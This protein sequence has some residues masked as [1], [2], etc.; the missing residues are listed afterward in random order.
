MPH[1][2]DFWLWS[3]GSGGG[4]GPPTSAGYA[5]IGRSDDVAAF[6]FDFATY[7]VTT[8]P[9][10]AEP[11]ASFGGSVGNSTEVLYNTNNSEV[12]ENFLFTFATE[13]M[14]VQDAGWGIVHQYDFSASNVANGYL[15][16]YSVFGAY[17]PGSG[18]VP[19]VVGY[20]IAT[21]A[22][23]SYS[24]VSGS[25]PLAAVPVASPQ[26]LNSA[27]TGYFFTSDIVF[28]TGA[29]T[30]F[31]ITPPGGTG[32]T[33]G[34]GSASCATQAISQSLSS[35]FAV[36][37]GSSIY[38]F[39]T[40]TTAAGP[41]FTR[42]FASYEMGNT[43]QSAGVSNATYGAFFE[44]SYVPD[45]FANGV[46]FYNWAQGTVSISPTALSTDGVERAYFPASSNPGNM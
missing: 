36:S 9:S 14:I 17:P 15:I 46:E 25:S 39:A 8:L 27:T 42:T 2:W 1:I 19:T 45:P 18:Y 28:A 29:S 43:E 21:F 32:I 34:I 33:P 7:A 37:F 6:R 30:A 16:L 38:T 23:H 12:G 41:A 5:I 13:A 10:F 40:N 4:G 24:P 26:P 20:V 31:S 3:T 11:F 35:E 44:W 22:S